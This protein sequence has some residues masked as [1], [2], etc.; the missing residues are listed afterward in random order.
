M[1]V[2]WSSTWRMKKSSQHEEYTGVWLETWGST[3]GQP[4]MSEKVSK[5]SYENT[6]SWDRCNI[7]PCYNYAQYSSHRSTYTNVFLD[8]V[9]FPKIILLR[10]IYHLPYVIYRSNS[11]IDIVL[12]ILQSDK[13]YNIIYTHYIWET[14]GWRSI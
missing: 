6:F 11:F 13:N 2:I 8:K 14:W 10:Y 3:D 4:M 1:L 12:S 9:I 5:L 7:F